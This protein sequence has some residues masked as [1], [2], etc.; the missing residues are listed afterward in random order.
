MTGNRIVPA[1]AGGPGVEPRDGMSWGTLVAHGLA[2]LV[3]LALL[4]IDALMSFRFGLTLGRTELDAEIY[5]CA[6]AL[7]DASFGPEPSWP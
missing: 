1:F 4:A 2:A 3:A 6:L 7:A 5:G